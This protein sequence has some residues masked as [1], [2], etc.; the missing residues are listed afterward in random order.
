M[1]RR[2][3]KFL[4]L[5]GGAVVACALD[6]RLLSSTDSPCQDA[7]QCADP[8]G[9]DIGGD[10]TGASTAGAST[11]GRSAAGGRAS[12]GGSSARGGANAMTAGA[13]ASSGATGEAGQEQVG[14]MSNCPDLDQ[15]T[16]LDC[17]E[18]LVT[19]PG[20]D[21]DIKG[22]SPE[23]NAAISWEALDQRGSNTSGSIRVEN[24]GTAS[25]P[26]NGLIY[27]GA[28]Q[29]VK[30]QPDHAYIIFAQMYSRGPGP[31]P[32]Y[33]SVVG[34]V[35]ASTDCSGTPLDIETS[36]IQGTFDSWLTLQA[37]VPAVTSAGSLLVELSVGKSASVTGSAVLNFDNVLVR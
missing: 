21:V 9:G 14:P 7:S 15:N 3:P 37:T 25:G 16:V 35:F 24:R 29:C 23:A 28:T 5:C 11:A 8:G 36:P 19:N 20:F 33:G 12:S 13:N 6:N 30:A 18:T 10:D 22:W 4:V 1:I 32:I 27:A 2:S 34:R 17:T 26:D 31:M